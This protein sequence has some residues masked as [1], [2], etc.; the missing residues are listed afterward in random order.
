[1]SMRNK[2]VRKLLHDNPRRLIGSA[3]CTPFSQMNNINYA[4]MS[5]EEIQRRMA[6]GR[7]HLEFCTKL[8][9]IQ[10]REGRYFLHEH[11]QGASSWQEGC[12]ERLMQKVGVQRVVGDQCMYG[13]KSWDGN[14]WGPSRK[15]TGFM[16][17]S[18]CI[19]VALQD[20]CP[21][22]QNQ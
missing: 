17:N 13:L 22:N 18:P 15:S 4:R 12:I 2:A 11:P 6:E 9:E 5:P 21:N 20:R 8:Y 14:R 10:W 16:T 19:A 7:R 3:I 1:M